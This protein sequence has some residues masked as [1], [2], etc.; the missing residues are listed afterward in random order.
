[1]ALVMVIED[2]PNIAMILKEVL[3]DEGHAVI[4]V[5]DGRAA[6]D[7]LRN[8]PTPQVA[9]VDLCMPVVGG[10]AVV[11]AIRADPALRN[12]RVVI[13]SGAVPT[14][15]ILPPKGSYEAYL[16]KPFD[17]IDLIGTVDG[18]ASYGK[19]AAG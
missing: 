18:L 5:G 15:D 4:T 14:P 8:G 2:E 16:S 3:T 11:E 19:V 6:L 9:L 13:I 17:L 10:R 7:Q 1:M 12:I